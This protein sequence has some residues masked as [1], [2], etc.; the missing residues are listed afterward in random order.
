MKKFTMLP[1]HVPSARS[2]HIVPTHRSHT[3][4][5]SGRKHALRNAS[6]HVISWRLGKQ[7]FN[8]VV[9]AGGGWGTPPP[10]PPKVSIDR[11]PQNQPGNFRGLTGWGGGGEAGGRA[12][13]AGCVSGGRGM[14]KLEGSL[15]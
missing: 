1:Q 7:L 14:E 8:V 5:H 4:L 11:T 6:T 2:E 9:A 15:T 13:M 10:P 3:R 12:A